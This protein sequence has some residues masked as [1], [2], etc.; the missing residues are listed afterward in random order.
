MPDV[1]TE[2][3]AERG[4]E[5]DRPKGRAEGG[6]DARQRALLRIDADELEKRDEQQQADALG[7][8]QDEGDDRGFGDP[9]GRNREGFRRQAAK[10]AHRLTLA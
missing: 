6:D 8:A 5:P 9:T 7:R 10:S 1:H 2:D 4:S 3:A